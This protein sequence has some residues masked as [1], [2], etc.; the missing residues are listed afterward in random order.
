MTVAPP[1][2]VMERGP[3]NPS[4]DLLEL[5]LEGLESLVAELGERPY[6]AL[7]IFRW[8]HLRGVRRI[9]EMTDISRPLR[10]RLASLA[11]IGGLKLS[12]VLEDADGTRKMLLDSVDGHSVEAVLIPME[13]GTTLCLSTQVGCNMG[14]EFCLT[15]RL[16]KQRNLTLG[17][18]VDQVAHGRRIAGDESGRPEPGNIVFMGM[19]EPLDNYEAVVAALRLLQHS[20]G[21]SLSSRRITVSTAG[22][23]PAIDRLAA[24]P[25][26]VVNLAV[27]LNATTNEQRERLMP[28]TR[29]YPLEALLAALRRFPVPQR[30]RMTIEY[31]LLAGVNDSPA[32]ARRLVRLLHGLRAKVNLLPFNPWPGSR[33]ARPP[34]ARVAKFQESLQERGVTATVRQSRG[35]GVGAACGQ[36]GE[37]PREKPE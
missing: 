18:I 32:D 22:L 31:V 23:V 26:L 27:S 25:D 29:A 14:C 37:I 24:E 35:R 7:Q 3:D 20:H 13:V 19:G 6:R 34:D 10:A 1:E 9:D 21:A 33:F 8:L 16:R 2:P 12:D 17:E 36:L 30:R 28:V 11:H 4:V 15:G 5:P